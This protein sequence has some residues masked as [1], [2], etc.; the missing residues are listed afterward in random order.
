MISSYFNIQKQMWKIPKINFGAIYQ[1][2]L[3]KHQ[4]LPEDRLMIFRKLFSTFFEVFSSE[5]QMQCT[6]TVELKKNGWKVGFMQKLFDG[7][8]QLFP[9]K[10]LMGQLNCSHEKVWWVSSIVLMKKLDGSTQLFPCQKIDGSTQLL[11]CKKL[12]GQLNCSHEKVWWVNTTGP[13]KK[14]DRST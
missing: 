3:I 2:Y 9:C 5:S 14:F 7:S 13:M 8:A 10:S 12:M 6:I 11:L 4:I 1:I